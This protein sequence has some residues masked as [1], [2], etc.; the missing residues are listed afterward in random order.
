MLRPKLTLRWKGQTT[1]VP[2]IV[3]VDVAEPIAPA[4][5][6][7]PRVLAIPPKAAR[8]AQQEHHDNVVLLLDRWAAWVITGEPIA[9]GAPRQC[10]GAPDSRIHSFEDMEIEVNKHIVRTVHTAVWELPVLE[11]E[12][13]MVHYGLDTRRV[14]RAQFAQVF[15][16]AV[17]GLYRTLKNRIAC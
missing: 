8:S 7:E 9:E 12:A 11:R 15:D 3:F 10:L 13:V 1:P 14:W 5:E 17:A 6:Q 2:D 4:V 16:Q